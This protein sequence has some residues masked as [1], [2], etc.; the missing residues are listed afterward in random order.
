M[1]K[2]LIHKTAE[3]E[4]NVRIGENTKI[5][6]FVQIRQ[7]S[8][9]GSNCII[10]KNVYIDFE[11]EIGNN[12]KIQNNCS[13]YHKTTIKGGVFIGPHVVITN[14]KNP[15]AI[16]IKGNVKTLK[17]WKAGKVIVKYG[18]SI[19]AGSIILP[20]VTIGKFA[21]VGAGSVVTSDVPDFAL[22]F[23]NPAKV[24]GKVDKS[25]SITERY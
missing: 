7:S 15:R 6:H 11:T 24:R 1:K 3:I 9:I 5:W 16:D 14:D 21:M 10:G 20:D 18:A 2:P 17:D 19:G 23:G 12:C 22:I 4:K 8:K 25:G 13:I